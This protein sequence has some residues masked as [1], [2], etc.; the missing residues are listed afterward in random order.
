VV[1]LPIL[2]A[3]FLLCTACNTESKDTL[4]D[5]NI[6]LKSINSK[7]SFSEFNKQLLMIYYI[8]PLCPHCKDG[9]GDTQQIANEYEPRGLASIVIALGNK[10]DILKFIEEQGASMPFFQDSENA[11][12]KKY[13]DKYVPK[14]Y[15][16]YPNGKTLIYENSERDIK[17]M[18]FDI[19]VFLPK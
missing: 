4:M 13:G 10:N 1:A 8:S 9:Y 12:I 15:L 16:V 6:P 19:D 17:K 7:K 11:F 3:L 18:V 2:L 14:H 5:F